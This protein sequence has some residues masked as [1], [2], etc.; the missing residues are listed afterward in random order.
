MTVATTT[1]TPP[2]VGWK[3]LLKCQLVWTQ[4]VRRCGEQNSTTTRDYGLRS[5]DQINNDSNTHDIWQNSD[6]HLCITTNAFTSRIHIQYFHFRCCLFD[7]GPSLP[8]LSYLCHFQYLD[9]L[10]LLRY[11]L[12]FTDIHWFRFSLIRI[13]KYQRYIILYYIILYWK[14]QYIAS[15]EDA[16]MPKLYTLCVFFFSVRIHKI[17]P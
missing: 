2:A 14:T 1:W 11:S 6:T 12:I 3:Y 17:R 15:H 16:T 9:R 4:F 7:D 8:F 13:F 10:D 5:T